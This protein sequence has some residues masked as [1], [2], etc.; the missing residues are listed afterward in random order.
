MRST[1][2]KYLETRTEFFAFGAGSL[3]GNR[4]MI[5]WET[6]SCG[7]WHQAGGVLGEAVC[8][9]FGA[10]GKLESEGRGMSNGDTVCS[11]RTWPFM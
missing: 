2:E 3:V 5:R 8:G 1:C 4:Q 7:G 6:G 11:G 10:V 9:I